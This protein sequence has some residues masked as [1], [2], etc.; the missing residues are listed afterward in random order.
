MLFFSARAPTFI[1]KLYC[2][3]TS[4]LDNQKVLE[5]PLLQLLNPPHYL[6]KN[7][8]FCPLENYKASSFLPKLRL[9][10]IINCYTNLIKCS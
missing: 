5:S 3:L 6:T 7:N 8:T 4:I 9:V 2:C 1:E 10:H